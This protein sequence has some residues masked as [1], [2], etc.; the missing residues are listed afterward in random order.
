MHEKLAGGSTVINNDMRNLW[1]DRLLTLLEEY[2]PRD[3]NN[4]D[5]M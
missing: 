4:I 3:T 1:P 2:Q 5:E